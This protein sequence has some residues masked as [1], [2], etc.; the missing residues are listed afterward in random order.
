MS[1]SNSIWWFCLLSQVWHGIQHVTTF[2]ITYHH[3]FQAILCRFVRYIHPKTTSTC[4]CQQL[5]IY[6]DIFA[7]I[8]ALFAVVDENFPNFA[9]TTANGSSFCRS[10]LVARS[11]KRIQRKRKQNLL[12]LNPDLYAGIPI[13][14][15][16]IYSVATWLSLLTPAKPQLALKSLLH[17]RLWK[18]LWHAVS[19]DHGEF[20]YKHLFFQQFPLWCCGQ[21]KASSNP[22]E[23]LQRN[24]WETSVRAYTMSWCC[25]LQV[26]QQWSFEAR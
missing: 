2:R 10:S 15:L 7:W 4:K 25:G 21:A 26:F 5:L 16:N 6:C 11:S 14:G 9:H 17:T 12:S 19:H 20:L 13:V 3:D 8:I 22:H 1:Q 24:S 23:Y 18:L